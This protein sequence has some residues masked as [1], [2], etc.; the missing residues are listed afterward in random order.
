VKWV[1]F[2]FLLLYHFIMSCFEAGV[3]GSTNEERMRS[4]TS[5]NLFIDKVPVSKG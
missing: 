2:V 4:S 1:A 5:K 3:E